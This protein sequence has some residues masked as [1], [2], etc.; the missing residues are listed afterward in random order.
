MDGQA[1]LRVL[2]SHKVIRS[3]LHPHPKPT[4]PLGFER[5][6]L[7]S[8]ERPC[9]FPCFLTGQTPDESPNSILG[10]NLILRQLKQLHIKTCAVRIGVS[11]T[12]AVYPSSS[13]ENCGVTSSRYVSAG[14]P[15][16]ERPLGILAKI[17]QDF[18]TGGNSG[19]LANKN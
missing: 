2:P 14:P 10:L 1:L 3:D 7:N 8:S 18:P 19:I 12:L 11:A 4:R 16:L 17:Q 13:Q 9:S 6:K 15:S 5:L